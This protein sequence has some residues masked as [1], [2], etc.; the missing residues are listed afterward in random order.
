MPKAQR[1]KVDP[2]V[3]VAFLTQ[4]QPRLHQPVACVPSAAVSSLRFTFAPHPALLQYGD[5]LTEEQVREVVKET[6]V[7]NEVRCRCSCPATAARP[8]VGDCLIFRAS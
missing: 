4:V 1:E 6:D 3:L 8:E 2:K 7:L 5:A